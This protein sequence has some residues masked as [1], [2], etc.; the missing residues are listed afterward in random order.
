MSDDE[1]VDNTLLQICVTWHI[2]TTVLMLL[3]ELNCVPVNNK[4]LTYF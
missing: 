2:S 4:I 1:S 3:L